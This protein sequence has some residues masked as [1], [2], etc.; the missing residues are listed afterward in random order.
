MIFQ[1]TE[2]VELKRIL[3]DGFERALVAFLNTLNGTI[4][5]GVEDNGAVVGVKNIDETLQKIADIVTMQ[6]IP[7]PQEFV[8]IGTK[9]IDGK[10]VIEVKVSKGNAQYYIKKFGRSASGCYIRV[11]TSNRSMTEE[12]INSG[13]I[14]FLD[15]QEKTIVDTPCLNQKLTFNMFKQYL[16][17]KGIHINE[18]TFNVNYHLITQEGK[19]NKLAF[20][21]ADEND[22]SIKVAIFKGT[23]K[24]KFSR[25]NE[26][27]NRCLISAAEKVIDYCDTIN[28]TFVDL[29]KSTRNETKMFDTEAFREAW[30]NACVHN[31]WIEGI[32]PAVYVFSDR[33]EIVSA[34]G[35]P[36]S[37]TREQFLSGESRPVN[38]ELMRAFMSCGLVEQSG[39]GVPIVVQKY[40]EEAY[41]L[42]AGFVKVTIPFYKQG[43]MVV[44]LKRGNFSFDTLVEKEQIDIDNERINATINATISANIKL[45]KTEIEVYKIIKANPHITIPKIVNILK[46]HK[47]TVSRAIAVLKEN[48]I[49]ERAG[50][51][52]TGH[53]KILA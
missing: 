22:I 17:G 47:A 7:N 4:Y 28:D 36:K 10:H 41:K 9:Y 5:I 18:K 19:Y 34:G 27:G 33:L 21:L 26:Y 3:N 48:K 42:D 35:I 44:N 43:Y 2:S 11:G 52:K 32:P 53:W 12:Q 23:D 20:L 31:A 51:N 30:L 46:K 13:L 38:P 49:I 15:R 25:R 6:I 40:G 37:M 16:T 14:S 50:S 45:S 29:G 39:H 1:E 8:D 24:T